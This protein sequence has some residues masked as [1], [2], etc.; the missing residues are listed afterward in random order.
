MRNPCLLFCFS[1][2]DTH[3]FLLNDFARGEIISS[4]GLGTLEEGLGLEEMLG[5]DFLGLG[6]KGL[7]SDLGSSND[8]GAPLKGQAFV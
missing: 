8:M 5:L 6:L 2:I 7:G 3:F 4:C 1:S